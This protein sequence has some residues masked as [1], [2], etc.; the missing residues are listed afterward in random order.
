[1]ANPYQRLGKRIRLLR[2]NAGLTQAK[3]AKRAE[4]S[5]N[6]IGL[7]ERGVGRP[8]LWT[9]DRIASALGVKLG[10][11]FVERNVSVS[12]EQAMREIQA[13]LARRDPGDAGLVVA[14]SKCV[15]ERF[16]EKTGR[17]G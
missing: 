14:L 9:V 6:F 11:L 10:E 2:R 15:F 4:L 7:I 16:P 12:R 5:D 17:V 1:M 13:L 8:T 3:L